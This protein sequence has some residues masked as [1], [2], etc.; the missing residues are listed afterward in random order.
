MIERGWNRTSRRRRSGSVGHE[1][2]GGRERRPARP[3]RSAL[4][5]HRQRRLPRLDQL[6]TAEPL[7]ARACEDPRGRADV[8]ALVR[9][10][11][12]I[13]GHASHNTTSV[14][15]PA[16]VFPMLPEALSTG[17][18]SLNENEDG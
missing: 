2:A 10:G 14:Y 1:P 4:G 18:T 3:A 5:V 17:L 11:S 16:A 7:A 6:T 13:D 9:K 12:A 15:T 8:D